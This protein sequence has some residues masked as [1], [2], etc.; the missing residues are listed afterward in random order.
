MKTALSFAVLLFCAAPALCQPVIKDETQTVYDKFKNQT[1]VTRKIA[2]PRVD[3]EP[4]ML[5]LIAIYPGR[6][7]SRTEMVSWGITF[8]SPERRFH[9]T[10]RRRCILL[11]D[12]KRID[13][14]EMMLVGSVMT[15]VGT[16]IE[17]ITAVLSTDSF[18]G[19]ARAKKIEMQVGDY[20]TTLEL[21]QLLRI[22][23]F[24]DQVEGKGLD[25]ALEDKPK[26]S[27]VCYDK[28]VKVPCPEQ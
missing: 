18:L 6:E 15:R 17:T 19:I 22:R 28:G 20:E 24:A 12:E 21:G 16:A 9:L 3:G 4:P 7:Y 13:L 5:Q 8:I 23:Q 2:L 10:H 14:G 25:R 11:V 27:A 26:P 1:T